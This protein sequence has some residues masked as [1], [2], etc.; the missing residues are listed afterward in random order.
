MQVALSSY[1][2][3]RLLRCGRCGAYVNPK[4]K[5]A[6]GGSQIVCNI[7]GVATP[8][9]LQEIGIGEQA[10][11]YEL[12]RGTYEFMAPQILHGKEI[13]GNNYV[14]VIDCGKNAVNSGKPSN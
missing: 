1:G 11:R 4:F 10:D 9:P 13:K 2:G 14:F 5:L 12:S 7:C 3:E 6:G 8:V